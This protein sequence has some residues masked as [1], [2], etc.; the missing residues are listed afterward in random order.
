MSSPLY[1]ALLEEGH[2]WVLMPLLSIGSAYSLQNC[3][4]QVQVLSEAPIWSH[5]LMERLLGYG[6]NNVSSNLAAITSI[7]LWCKG[8]TE[9]FDIYGVS[10]NLT[11]ATK[12]SRISIMVVHRYRKP[13]SEGSNPL[14]GSKYALFN[15]QR[16]RSGH[17]GE[18]LKTYVAN[19]PGGS[20][21]SRCA[22]HTEIW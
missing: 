7:A 4:T 10:S 14:F 13:Q 6:P 21:P 22:I 2:P 3:I 15:T 18:V 5:R 8:S 17:N 12:T 9:V 1:W 16:Y 11:R 19:C 20:S